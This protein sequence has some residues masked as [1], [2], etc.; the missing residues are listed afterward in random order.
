[1]LRAGCYDR[2][3]AI[4]V[5][6]RKGSEHFIV[7]VEAGECFYRGRYDIPAMLTEWVAGPYPHPAGG[8]SSVWEAVMALGPR[9]IYLIMAD[10]GG[11]HVAEN[12]KGDPA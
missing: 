9:V 1:M 5:A 2:D 4:A 6:E 12:M 7:M 8:S 3:I 11:R 10:A